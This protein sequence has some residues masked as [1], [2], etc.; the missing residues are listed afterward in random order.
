MGLHIRRAARRLTRIYDD[1]LA[2]L[3]LT[4]GQF[5]LLAMLAGREVWAMQPL[6]DALGTDRSSLTAALKPLERRGLV[7]SSPDATDRRLRF[8]SLTSQGIA[9]MSDAEPLWRRAQEAAETLLGHEGAERLRQTLR[10][11]S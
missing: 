11:L 5:S 2:P 4:I 8:L 3:D 10:T 9:L 1:S 7:G 6:A